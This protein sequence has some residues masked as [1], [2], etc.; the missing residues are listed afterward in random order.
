MSR[1]GST[2]L[3]QG[4]EG[5]PTLVWTT[6]VLGS[7][8]F[9][10]T[11][12]SIGFR[13]M[14]N[15]EFG[16]NVVWV[17]RMVVCAHTAL[18]HLSVLLPLPY[19]TF[20]ITPVAFAQHIYATYY[21]RIQLGLAYHIDYVQLSKHAYPPQSHDKDQNCHLALQLSSHVAYLLPIIVLWIRSPQRPPRKRRLHG[22]T[23][24]NHCARRLFHDGGD[25]AGETEKS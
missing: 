19:H 12:G 6:C 20:T 11:A 7:G 4:L 10:A 2:L 14:H 18:L 15:V 3:A 8:A 13:T 23:A 17:F 16:G 21:H 1:T 25:V 24:R 22:E 5:G 9:G